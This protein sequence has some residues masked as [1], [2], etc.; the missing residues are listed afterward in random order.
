MCLIVALISAMYAL[1]SFNNNDPLIGI[2]SLAVSIFFVWLMLKNIFY[3]KNL[4]K[5][6]KDDN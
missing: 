2:I 1:N 6:N 5:E 3:I 4:K